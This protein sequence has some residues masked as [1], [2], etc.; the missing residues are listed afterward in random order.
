MGFTVFTEV[1]QNTHFPEVQDVTPEQVK[2]V[3]DQVSIIDV[4]EDDEWI[5]ELGHISTAKLIN[6]GKLPDK[7]SEV[8]KDK[9]VVIVC[10]SGGRSARATA[11][12][13]QQG[14]NY[15]YNMQG[16]MILWNQKGLPTQR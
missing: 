13:K 3:Q 11:F 2:K 15:V 9:P 8:P 1:L 14:F 4:R 6:L 5:S 16:G 7:V 10:R 12:L